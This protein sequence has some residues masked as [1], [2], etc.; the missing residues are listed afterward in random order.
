[1]SPRGSER[2]MRRTGKPPL[3][4]EWR[5]IGRALCGLV[6]RDGSAVLPSPY[7]NSSVP[8]ARQPVPIRSSTKVA[9]ITGA[10]SKSTG[11][12]S[13]EL[14][15]S[16]FLPTVA[17]RALF[18]SFARA[19]SASDGLFPTRS[20]P[21]GPGFSPDPARDA[22]RT[23]CVWNAFLLNGAL[24]RV[25]ARDHVCRD[26]PQRCDGSRRFR[27]T[28]RHRCRRGVLHLRYWARS[29]RRGSGTCRTARL[30]NDPT[31]YNTDQPFLPLV[32]PD[33]TANVACQ[34]LYLALVLRGN[35]ARTAPFGATRRELPKRRCS[36]QCWLEA[37]RRLL[38]R[39]RPRRRVCA[40]V[41]SD[42]TAA[43]ARLRNRR[44]WPVLRR[45][46]AS[47][48]CSTPAS[49]SRVFPFTSV[50][51]D[52]PPLRSR[53]STTIRGR[54]AV[55]VPVD[56]RSRAPRLRGASPPRRADLA[57]LPDRVG[58]ASERNASHSTQPLDR[59][60]GLH[61][62]LLALDSLP[63]RLHRAAERHPAAVLWYRWF[64]GL[65]PYQI[66]HRDMQHETRL[67][68]QR[69][70]RRC[71]SSSTRSRAASPIATTRCCSRRPRVCASSPDPRGENARRDRHERRT[72]HRNAPRSGGASTGSASP[73]TSSST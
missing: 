50:A 22:A 33:L 27:D 41:Q 62:Y 56:H 9:S 65:V 8:S 68:A 67:C 37:R 23:G 2:P 59:R 73:P 64:T 48:T 17:A 14:L 38:L 35:W 18:A 5:T 6:S 29:A 63:H 49:S 15:S 55:E 40:R 4:R 46:A 66:E 28:R 51:L 19:T 16:I 57:A 53:T 71:S 58:A 21:D 47:A 44:R 36:P 13:A 34:R 32:A 20:P 54:A 11:T 60:C 42:V 25:R 39:P 3:L 52:D 7:A 10:G 30:G 1:M 26:G 70:W 24:S 45:F 69:R 61:R 72:G 12:I 43:R 31:R